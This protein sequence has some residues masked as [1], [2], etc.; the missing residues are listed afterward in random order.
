MGT[1]FDDGRIKKKRDYIIVIGVSGP[2]LSPLGSPL[3][4]GAIHQVPVHQA[5]LGDFPFG[6][7]RFELRHGG[8]IH[9]V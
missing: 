2:W 8:G 9:K 4:C 6:C 3:G 7:Q 5:L 1:G